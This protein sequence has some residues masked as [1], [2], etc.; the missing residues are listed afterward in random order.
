MLLSLV[1]VQS[2]LMTESKPVVICHYI[3]ASSKL[4]KDLFSNHNCQMNRTFLDIPIH[5][6][7]QRCLSV[8]LCVSSSVS[9]SL[10]CLQELGRSRGGKHSSPEEKL[11]EYLINLQ[12]KNRFDDTNVQT[13]VR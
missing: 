5:P 10:C 7:C 12:H 3:F 9:E 13:Q 8:C 4:L 11:D 6:I 1:N 2:Q